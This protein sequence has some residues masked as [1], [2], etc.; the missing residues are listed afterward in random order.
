MP[1]L[2]TGSARI[3]NTVQRGQAR[4]EH[5]VQAERRRRARR[6]QQ[7]PDAQQRVDADLGHDREHGRDRRTCRAVALHQ[8]EVQRPGARLHQEG[9]PQDG[10]PGFEQHAFGARQVAGA[11]G[12]V[13]HVQRAGHAIDQRDADQ[14]QE[15]SH[16][17][18][19]SRP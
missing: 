15:R 9:H 17:P 1:M 2:A 11:Q 4:R 16:Q 13:R 5:P 8:P 14:Q 6:Q 12:Q 10:G 18:C 3:A 19:S 7:R